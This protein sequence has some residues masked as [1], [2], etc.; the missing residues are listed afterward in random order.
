MNKYGNHCHYESNT[1]LMTALSGD[2]ELKSLE[3]NNDPL[4]SFIQL[5][6]KS[7]LISYHWFMDR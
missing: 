7:S 6:S 1:T 5:V 4:P 2:D 3:F